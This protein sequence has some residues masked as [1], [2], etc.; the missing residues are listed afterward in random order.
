[1]VLY[2]KK[3]YGIEMALRG[4]QETSNEGKR[5]DENKTKSLSWS[6]FGLRRIILGGTVFG[7]VMIGLWPYIPY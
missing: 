3:M 4:M 6:P 5:H 2:Q 7:V 1:M